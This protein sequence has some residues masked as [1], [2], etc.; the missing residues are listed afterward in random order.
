VGGTGAGGSVDPGVNDDFDALGEAGTGD[1]LE[2]TAK[3]QPTGEPNS[4]YVQRGS[5]GK[6][7]QVTIYDEDGMAVGHVDYKGNTIDG[8]HILDPPGDLGSGHGSQGGHHYPP[9]EGRYLMLLELKEFQRR[10]DTLH[11]A[12]VVQTTI[13]YARRTGTTVVVELVGRDTT[14]GDA[15]ENPKWVGITLRLRKCIEY[16]LTQQWPH[17]NAVIFQAHI[18][19]T[20]DRY[21]V[22]LDARMFD[23]GIDLTPE[24]CRSTGFFFCAEELEISDGGSATVPQE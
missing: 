3:G 10:F 19:C 1:T 8:G 15:F 16:G 2:G 6:P 12:I 17:D 14:V 9:E 4:R 23:E 21:W 13:N 7:K 5:N 22:V 24:E 11:D 20:D 18:Q